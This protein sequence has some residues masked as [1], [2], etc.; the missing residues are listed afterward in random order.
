M[1]D[2]KLSEYNLETGKFEIKHGR[3]R[4]D[5]YHIWQNMKA[6]CVNPNHQSFKDYGGRG[7]KVCD[8][9][10]KF[11]NFL[12]D[13]GER[14]SK[15]HSLD[16]INN[17]GNYEAN[18]CRW[19]T[20]RQ[21]CTNTRY[22]VYITFKEQTKTLSEWCEESGIEFNRA[23]LRIK[24]GYPLDRVFDPE[25]IRNR[26]ILREKHYKAR[27]DEKDVEFII[28]SYISGVTGVKLAKRFNVGEEMIYNILRGKTYKRFAFPRPLAKN[29]EL[30][31][32]VK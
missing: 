13:M 30:W 29:P 5:I 18:N 26:E 8:E 11:E 7:I 16:R 27:F 20:R 2:L 25:P 28:K 23:R 14:P 22:N 6:R 17:N 31:Q 1:I 32:E 10:L 12:S 24:K 4:D 15:T 3:S 19:A 9:W 21:Q